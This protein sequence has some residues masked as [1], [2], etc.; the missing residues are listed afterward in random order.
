M[1]K[2][3]LILAICGISTSA[4]SLKAQCNGENDN[5]IYYCCGVGPTGDQYIMDGFPHLYWVANNRT[6]S[7]AKCPYWPKGEY[8]QI[9]NHLSY[10]YNWKNYD[11]CSNKTFIIVDQARG[12]QDEV[13]DPAKNPEVKSLDQKCQNGE[14]FSDIPV[15]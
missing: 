15:Q 8:F 13:N 2:I 14:I 11:T 5:I 1:K 3:I 9:T 6:D 12:T 7:P 10:Y 4:F